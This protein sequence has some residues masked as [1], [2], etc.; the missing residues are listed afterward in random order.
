MCALRHGSDRDGHLDKWLD[1]RRRTN[2]HKR[3]AEAETKRSGSCMA[4]LLGSAAA[5]KP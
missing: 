1:D 4:G 2:E 3:W 5:A